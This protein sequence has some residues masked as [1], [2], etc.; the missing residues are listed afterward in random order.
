MTQSRAIVSLVRDAADPVASQGPVLW[1]M[2]QLRDTLAAKGIAVQEQDAGEPGA[3]GVTI[4]VAGPTSRQAQDILAAAGASLPEDPEALALAERYAGGAGRRPAVLAAGSDV[5]G[6]VYA[7][8]ELADRVMYADG[9]AL[10][11]LR[12]K[13]PIVEA[14]PNAIR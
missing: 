1:A 6:L 3:G 14:S 9:D 12:I 5:R 8:L 13:E 11:V 2:A 10:D 7:V 4:L